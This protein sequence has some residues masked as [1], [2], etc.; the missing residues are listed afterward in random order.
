MKNNVKKTNIFINISLGFF[1]NR[2]FL[3]MFKINNTY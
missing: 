1:Y 3:Y 2:L